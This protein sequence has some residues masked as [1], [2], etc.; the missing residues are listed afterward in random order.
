[1]GIVTYGHI[2]MG[3]GTSGHSAVVGVCPLQVLLGCIFSYKHVTTVGHD[4]HEMCLVS[5]KMEVN[6]SWG[7][8]GPL[9]LLLP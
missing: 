7:F 1:M 3:I 8:S 6:L 2:A 5:L 4:W 9:R